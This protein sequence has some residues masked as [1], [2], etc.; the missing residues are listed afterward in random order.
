MRLLRLPGTYRPQADTRL[1]ATAF[2]E[3]GLHGAGRVLDVGTGTGAVALAAA[4]SGNCEVTAVDVSRQAVWTARVNSAWRRR[5]VAVL[6]GDLLDP[7]VGRT[8]DVV[9]ANPPYVP[10]PEENM[11]PR[12]SSRAWDAGTDGRFVLDR[13]CAQI[14]GFL[15]AGGSLLVVHSVLCG[16]G[17]TLGLLESV[18]LHAQVVAR[19]RTPFG[20]VLRERAA[21]LEERGLVAPGCREEELVVI[22]GDAQR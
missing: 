10:A 12:G 5:R 17:A 8:F 6:C 18:G 9:L 21:F 19:R 22:R 13:L 16:V 7:V 20:P 4:A 2:V 3:Q 14:P 1:L 11:P 15:N